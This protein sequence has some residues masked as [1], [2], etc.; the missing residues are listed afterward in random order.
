MAGFETAV[1]EEGGLGI[2]HNPGDGKFSGKRWVVAET[3]ARGAVTHLRQCVKGYF[4][5]V[6]KLL[7]PRQSVDVVQESTAGVG[8]I[9]CEYLAIG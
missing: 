8:G 5:Q 4:K 7:V 1:A 6:A 3:E 2:S 9:G